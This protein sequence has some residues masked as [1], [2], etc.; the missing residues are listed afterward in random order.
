[1]LTKGTV[2][3]E[4]VR[5][6]DVVGTDSWVVLALLLSVIRMGCVTKGL[7]L[8]SEGGAIGTWHRDRWERVSA[9]APLSKLY[10]GLSVHPAGG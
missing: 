2:S 10:L 6:C 7:V 3:R 9:R 4:T 8:F 1:M 5:T